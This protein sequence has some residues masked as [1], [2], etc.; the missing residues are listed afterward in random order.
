M[1]RRVLFGISGLLFSA[2]DTV[3]TDV[4]ARAAISRKVIFF[5]IMASFVLLYMRILYII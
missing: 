4:P 2:F 1:R 5:A 3:E